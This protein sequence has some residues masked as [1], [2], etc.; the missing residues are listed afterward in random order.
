MA[1]ENEG[2]VAVYGIDGTI[3][4]GG[5]AKTENI[6][7][8]ANLTDNFRV[9]KLSKNGHIIGASADEHTQSATFTLVVYDP[10]ASTS[11]LAAAKA[12]VEMPAALGAVTA[13]DFD[14]ALY[15]G[16]WTYVG[17]GSVTQRE[18]GH[19]EI[20]LPCERYKQSDG[21]YK[22]LSEL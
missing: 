4:F 18:D 5:L 17:G 6:V 8:G 21:T 3:A 7:K 10:T 19:L 16:V 13:D 12:L 20:T 9:A 22:A 1:A 15:D 2:F 11:N 14:V